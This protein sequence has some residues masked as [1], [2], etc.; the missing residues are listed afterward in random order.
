MAWAEIARVPAWG[1]V[2]WARLG[3]R[4]RALTGRAL[5]ARVLIG[6]GAGF[7][8]AG[9]RA[10]ADHEFEGYILLRGHGVAGR[11]HGHHVPAD[12]ARGAAG[13]YLAA[14]QAQVMTDIQIQRVGLY[15]AAGP[16]VLGV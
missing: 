15:R 8:A 11:G 10:R 2:S 3:A 16:L 6:R 9:A 7:L 5:V 4:H 1:A 14:E 13:L 12:L